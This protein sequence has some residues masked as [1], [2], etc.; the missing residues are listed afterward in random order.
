M[1]ST[2]WENSAIAHARL[3]EKTVNKKNSLQYTIP[4][5]NLDHLKKLTTDF[6]MIQFSIINQPDINSGYTLD[7]NAR[8]LVAMCQ[9]YELTKDETNISYIKIYLDFIKYCLQ[10]DG[11]FLNYVDEQTRFTDQN[12]ETNLAD[13][14]GR[15]IWALGY[16]ISISALLPK[17]YQSI[18]NDAESIFNDALLNVNK[19]HSTRAMAFAIKGLYYRNENS[20]FPKN[21]PLIQ[22]L[23]NRLVQ[24]YRHETDKE[25]YWFESYLT[26]ANSILPEA[27][28]C[29]WL[30]T[31]DIIY[32]EI[33]Q[34]SFDF[35]LSKT[36]TENHI[37]VIS[38]KTW[39]R[40]GEEVAPRAIGGEQ[41]IDV[42]YT[43][44]ALNKFYTV[45]K[46]EKYKQIMEK[47]FNWFLGANHLQQIIYNP[48]TGGCYDGLEENY[49][50][51]NQG[52]ESTV[53]YLMARLTLEKSLQSNPKIKD[54][55]AYYSSGL[56][57]PVAPKESNGNAK[58]ICING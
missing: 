35:L 29:A 57:N 46:V 58:N 22:Q 45:F 2:A 39:L 4:D 17:E 43:I 51:L 21:I 26:Y 40:R 32:K 1:A 52:A 3:L 37:K 42:S 27:M 5:I 54:R 13:A 7:D 33:A 56:S 55:K 10:K 34:T 23:A 38:N 36:F 31:G 8:A 9:H 25:W 50:N 19:I 16:F 20:Q 30:A 24:M 12:S 47:S 53:S 11:F 14:N 28:L 48:C 18:G 44:M 49:V 15:A 41:P 6:G